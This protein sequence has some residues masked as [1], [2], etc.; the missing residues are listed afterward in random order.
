MH[1]SL[2]TLLSFW[3]LNWIHLNLQ[4][5]LIFGLSLRSSGFKL[6]RCDVVVDL[7]LFLV[8]FEMLGLFGWIL[9][10]Q[11][12]GSLSLEL[13]EVSMSFG[14]GVMKSVLVL[15]IFATFFFSL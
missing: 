9:Q 4:N 15:I 8:S 6:S 10:L 7:V 13:G 12:V 3:K 2:I 14:N 5:K 11:L 1:K